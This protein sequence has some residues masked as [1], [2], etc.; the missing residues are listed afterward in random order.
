MTPRGR[1]PDAIE[2]RLR[3]DGYVVGVYTRRDVSRGRGTSIWLTDTGKEVEVV[4]VYV[5][6][7][8]AR[9]FERAPDLTV[10]GK[11]V[12]F[13]RQGRPQ[14]SSYMRNQAP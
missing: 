10:A 12:R 9:S 5:S 1:W 6:E 11:V 8:Q 7:V 14:L 13:L 4:A 2:E 3:T